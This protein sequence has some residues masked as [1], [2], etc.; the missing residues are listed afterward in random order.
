MDTLY[1]SKCSTDRLF[2]ITLHP[3]AQPAQFPDAQFLREGQDGTRAE[4]VAVCV[5]SGEQQVGCDPYRLRG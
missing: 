1:T 5:Q 2:S 3:A 4:N